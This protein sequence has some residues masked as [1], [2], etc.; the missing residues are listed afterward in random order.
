MAG[1][2]AAAESVTS[3]EELQGWLDG[4]RP[5]KQNVEIVL[6]KFLLPVDKCVDPTSRG[7]GHSIQ[8]DFPPV[9]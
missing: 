4:A 5:N 7:S 1:T 6:L 8:V 9:S 2:K 3:N